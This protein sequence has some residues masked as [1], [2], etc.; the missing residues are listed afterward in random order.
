MPTRTK[1]R[2]RTIAISGL[3]GLPLCLV[4][5][6]GALAHP[7]VFV[8]G[9]SEIVIAAD[10]RVTAVRQSWTFDEFFSAAAAM[11]HDTDGDGT[12]T[13][14][15]LAP[16]A[17]VN[18]E[19]LSEYDFFTYLTKGGEDIAFAPPQEYWLD[20]ADGLLTLNV[21]LPLKTPVSAGDGPLSLEVYDPS[22]YVAFSFAETEPLALSAGAP[23]CALALDRGTGPTQ[24]Q[25]SF[26][27]QFGRDEVL[28]SSD[29]G[30]MFAEKVT[31]TCK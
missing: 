23:D 14:E 1:A 18:V 19:S 31:I 8:T 30:A 13:R 12:Y 10:G 20:F 3:A 25:Q 5:A 21:T 24:A 17:K 26:L 4:A 2:M 15:E 7:H 16:L 29:F 9:K 11:G 22:Y 6:Q 27:S 28:P